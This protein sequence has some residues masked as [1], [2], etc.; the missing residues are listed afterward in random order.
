ML[1]VPIGEYDW[2]VSE[3]FCRT[4]SMLST[5]KSIRIIKRNQRERLSAEGKVVPL[6]LA[7][8][9]REREMLQTVASWIAERRDVAKEFARS[10]R[11][12]L[13]GR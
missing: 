4:C 7:E 11:T 9:Q 6:A 1:L 8:R 10:P 12:I 3:E 2:A 13:K 5:E